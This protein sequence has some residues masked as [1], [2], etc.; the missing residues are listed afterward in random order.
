MN[1]GNYW[2]VIKTIGGPQNI[3]QLLFKREIGKE[4]WINRF[5]HK[6]KIAFRNIGGVIE[7]EHPDIQAQKRK[8][9]PML[10][11]KN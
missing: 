11:W 4:A 9:C 1:A 5:V 8:P 2:I 3:S 10:D 6:R 7:K